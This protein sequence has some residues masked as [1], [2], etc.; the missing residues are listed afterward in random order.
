MPLIKDEFQA[1]NVSG[2]YTAATEGV[3]QT[4][5]QKLF[6]VRK[7]QGLNLQFI[8]GAKN[9][10]IVLR[11]SAF[12]VKATF[13]DR[14]SVQINEQ[15]MPFFKEA[16][17]IKE[18]DRQ[19]LLIIEQTKNQVLIDQVVNTIMNDHVQLVTGAHARLEAM[20]MQVLATGTLA[21]NFNGV[22]LD[23]DY[24]VLDSNKGDAQV[25]WSETATA[26]PLEDIANAIEALENLGSKAEVLVMNSKTY[27]LLK[28]A[29]NTTDTINSLTK[30]KVT[31]NELNTYLKDEHELTIQIVNDTYIDDDGETKKYFP[32]NA[33]TI[34]PNM[35]VGNTVFGTTPA[36]MDLVSGQNLN[37]SIVDTGI[38]VV[39]ETT[40][41]PVNTQTI[42][43]MVALPSFEG[44]D[45]VYMLNV[46]LPNA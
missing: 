44:V 20:R 2:Y 15:Q 36:E 33:V 18:E 41:D 25:P 35:Q 6:P 7:Q 9:K 45:M 19:Q 43:S 14:M 40:T 26:K 3:D 46:G 29:Q 28:N 24:G 12:D 13:R 27:T 42:V 37:V 34:M 10:P 22:A 17:A 8:K 5:G 4:I 38:A 1:A 32:D 39:S 11:P 31:K 30:L 23:Y 21:V 16:M